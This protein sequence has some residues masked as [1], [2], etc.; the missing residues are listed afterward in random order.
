M[1]TPLLRLHVSIT[2]YSLL[3]QSCTVLTKEK[4]LAQIVQKYDILYLDVNK[5]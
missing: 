4:N 3:E 5:E 2:F 1:T